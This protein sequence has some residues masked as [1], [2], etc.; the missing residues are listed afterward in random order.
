MSE[1]ENINVENEETIGADEMLW[2][3]E[4]KVAGEDLLATVKKL[5]HEAG[6]RRIVIKNAEQRLLLE[7]P[8]VL[9]IA[10]IAL[11]PVWSAVALIAALV[12]DCAIYVERLKKKGEE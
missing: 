12:T 6:V 2:T 11:L 3:E 4:I 7:I 8:L 10:G 1:K 9:G 5:V